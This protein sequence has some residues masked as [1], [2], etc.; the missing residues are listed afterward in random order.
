MGSTQPLI[1]I[2]LGMKGG[3]RVKLTTSPPSVNRLSRKCGSL[4]VSQSHGPPRPVTGIALPL[5]RSYSQPCYNYLHVAESFLR[6]H[7]SLSYSRISQHFTEPKSSL[8][9]SQE[10]STG[11]YPKPNESSPY[12]L[13]LLSFFFFFI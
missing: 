1:E 10:L 5:P 11:P 6:S 7:Q 9:S 13:I 12:L 3:Q 2:F 4:D 8:L